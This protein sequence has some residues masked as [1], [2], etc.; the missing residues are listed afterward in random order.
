MEIIKVDLKEN[1]YNI[2]I[3]ENLL[4]QKRFFSESEKYGNFAVVLT[5]KKILNLHQKYINDTLKKLPCRILTIPEGEKSKSP[6]QALK[7]IKEIIKI[8]RVIKR[9]LFILCLGGGVIGDLGGFIASIYKRGIPYI[10]I[11]TTLLS[12][13]D[14][15]IGGKT[16]I[17]LKEAK[18]IIGTFYQPKAVFVDLNFLSTLK[19]KE[20]KEGFSEIIKYAVIQDKNLFNFLKKHYQKLKRLEISYLKKVIK[21]CAEIK[22]RIVEKDEKEKRGIRTIL[23]F[24]HTIAHALESSMRYSRKITHGKAVAL[25]MIGE[26]YISYF[27]RLCS[28]EEVEKITNIVQL[29]SLPTKIQFDLLKALEA[30]KQDKKFIKGRIRIVVIEKIGKAFVKEDIPFKIIKKA[31]E[32]I[33]R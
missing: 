17:N 11:P 1:S 9:R 29:Y 23:N 15:S 13:V 8:D 24:G 19:E 2:Y 7:I 6:K 10:Q 12:C 26:G 30:L 5:H 32:K 25:G 18:N 31:L 3:G 27:L 28:K 21:R 33:N 22:A 4:K 14:A 16:A 20:I